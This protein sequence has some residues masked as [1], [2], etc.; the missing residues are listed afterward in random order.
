M[1]RLKE[2]KKGQ[3]III[4][5]LLISIMIISVATIMYGAVTY[6]RHERWEEYLGVIDAI[7]TNSHRLMEASLANYT[8]TGNPMIL[9]ANMDKWQRD[10]MKTYTGHGIV[11]RSSLANGTQTIYGATLQFSEGLATE[12]NE[13]VSFSAANATFD[14]NM[15]AIGLSGYKFITP[16][17]LKM[18]ITD[19]LYHPASD[20]V[21]V[22]LIIQ[23]ENLVFVTDLQAANFI[24][25]EIDGV[26]KNVTSRHYFDSQTHN[27]FIY[28]LRYV[29]GGSNPGT[30]GNVTIGVVDTRGIK[31]TGQALN[32]TVTDA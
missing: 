1:L 31:V 10:L 16:V 27:A 9:K 21:G 26:S 18:N 2:N 4:A 30:L 13:Q 19:A 22:R 17:F 5:T 32:V 6:F 28:E 14:L 23:Q 20:E 7:E 25:F 11:L 12:W 15:T 24:V 8:L 3:F 29:H